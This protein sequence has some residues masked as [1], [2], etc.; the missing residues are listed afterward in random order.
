MELLKVEE[1]NAGYGRELVLKDIDFSME[2]GSL[3]GL[4]GLNGA[5]K[6][7][8]LRV[9]GGLL[10]P[11]RGQVLVHGKDIFTYREKERAK[12]ISFMPQRHSIVYDTE[13]IDIVL[14]GINPYLGIFDSPSKE[15]RE[16]AYEAL[17]YVGM[18]DKHLSNFLHL[19]EG[20]RQLVI[21]ARALLQ[22]S[23]I[24][25]FDEPNS[26]LDF[27]NSH[28]VLSKIREIIKSRG[29][30]GIITLHDPNMVLNYCDSIILLKDGEIFGH[31]QV[32]DIDRAFVQDVFSKIYDDIETIEYKKQFFILR[33]S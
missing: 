32:E 2:S 5:G 7:T 31:F 1:I 28:M 15:D 26:T 20:Q 25:L 19:S 24:M 8:L 16:K 29:K 17:K 21:V 10:N 30:S 9:I 23:E 3:L 14:M 18:E 22:N 4:L 6:T 12:H 13:V 11:L 27:N 33:K